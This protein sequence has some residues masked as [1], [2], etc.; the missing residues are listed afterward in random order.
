MLPLF[1][2]V[3]GKYWDN[4]GKYSDLNTGLPGPDLRAAQWMVRGGAFMSGTDTIGYEV[5]NEGIGGDIHV[6]MLAD[7]GVQIIEN[8]DL[9]NARPKACLLVPVFRGPAQNCWCYCV[10]DY[11]D[12]D[13]L[14]LVP[15]GTAP[16]STTCS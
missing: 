8:L 4:P 16:T 2:P 9:E 6:F 10:A 15:T 13:L 11:T 12:R 14:I 5:F 3:G 7:Q 1:G